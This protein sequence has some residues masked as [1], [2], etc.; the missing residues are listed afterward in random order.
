[1]ILTAYI[2]RHSACR[3]RHN[4]YGS[5]YLN[6]PISMNC[7]RA[8]TIAAA[9]LGAQ[10]ARCEP[11]RAQSGF[12]GPVGSSSKGVPAISAPKPGLVPPKGFS[13]PTGFVGGG[14]GAF[15]HAVFQPLP[16]MAPQ[17][18]QQNQQQCPNCNNGTLQNGSGALPATGSSPGGLPGLGSSGAGGCSSGNCGGSFGA[19]ASMSAGSRSPNVG[20]VSGLTALTQKAGGAAISVLSPLLTATLSNSNNNQRPP[21]SPSPVLDFKKR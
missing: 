7:V 20:I 15:T 16:N 10:V 5:E 18:E 19:A 12:F 14:S 3:F 21:A 11:A 8:L 4:S 17:Q 1:M 2:L 13:G 6:R 9:T